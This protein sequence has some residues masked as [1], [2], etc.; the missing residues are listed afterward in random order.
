MDNSAETSGE[1]PISSLEFCFPQFRVVVFFDCWIFFPCQIQMMCF[2]HV[3]LYSISF[4]KSD[5]IKEYMYETHHLNLTR[6]K[7]Q[8]VIKN[9][10]SKLRKTKFKK[11]DG[12]LANKHH[13]CTAW[14]KASTAANI[15]TSK[16]FTG[17][18]GR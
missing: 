16:N 4:A 1:N 3:L 15:D 2:V 8:T 17:E 6:K 18:I 12:D 7:D 13:E 5:A 11:R 9:D 10:H 14:E